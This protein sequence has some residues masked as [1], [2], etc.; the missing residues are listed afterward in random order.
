M[1]AI[2]DG[3]PLAAIAPNGYT[4]LMTQTLA[5]IHAGA[6]PDAVATHP[7]WWSR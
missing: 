6:L 1:P 5:F 7:A 2:L 4:S 3:Q